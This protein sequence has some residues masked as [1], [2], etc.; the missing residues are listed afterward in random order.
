MGWLKLLLGSWIY[1]TLYN[2]IFLQERVISGLPFY[3]MRRNVFQK[4]DLNQILPEIFSSGY[5]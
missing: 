1:L 2:V 3:K 4:K 5:Y